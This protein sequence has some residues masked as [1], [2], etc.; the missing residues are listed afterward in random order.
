[1]GRYLIVSLDG[2]IVTAPQVMS[3]I[4]DGEAELA[5]Y[6]DEDFATTLAAQLNSG[7]LP[8]PLVPVS[9]P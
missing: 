3:P 2:T 8:F 6:F 5:G 4:P 1:V 7:P 9:G